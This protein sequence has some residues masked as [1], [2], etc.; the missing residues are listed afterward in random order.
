MAL[1]G[2]GGRDRWPEP[3]HGEGRW[4]LVAV[5][6]GWD[7]QA[8]SSSDTRQAETLPALARGHATNKPVHRLSGWGYR[9]AGGLVVRA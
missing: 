9:M 1:G 6:H 5:R 2:M 7:R 3:R 8:P 4:A